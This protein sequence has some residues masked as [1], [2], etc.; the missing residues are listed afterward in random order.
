MERQTLLKTLDRLES[1]LFK[2][3][4]NKDFET[5][6]RIIKKENSLLKFKKTADALV[7][8]ISKLKLSKS[9]QEKLTR[10]GI[11]TVMDILSLEPLRVEDYSLKDP[12]SVKNGEYCAINGTVL[13]K[14]RGLRVLSIVLNAKGI[15]IRCNWF[16]LTPYIKR[17]LSSI[18]L[19]DEVVCLGKANRDGFLLQLNHPKLTKLEEFKPQ[20]KI[21][22]PSMGL[23][24]STIEKAKEKAML[25]LPKRPFDYL[26]YSVISKNSLPLLDEFFEHLKSD[27]VNEQIQKRQKYEEMFFLLLG[28]KLQEKHLAQKTAPSIETEAGFLDEVKKH[29]PFELTNGQI[30]AIDEILKDMARSRPM[31]RLLQGDVGCGKTVVALICALAALKANYQVAIMAPTQPLAVQFFLQAENLFKHFNIKTSLLISSTKQKEA[32]YKEIKDGQIDC[33]IGTHALIEEQVEFKNLGFIVIDE[34]HRFG[35]EQ[36][37]SLSSKGKF[38]HVLLMSA[39]PIPRSLSMVLYS[40][41]SLSTIKE[42]PKNRGNLKTLHFYK[43]RRDEA[44]RIALDE[45]NKKHQVYVIVPLIDESEHFEDYKAAIRLYEELRD[46]I[47]RDFRVELLHGKIKPD[48]KDAI[49]KEFRQGKIDCLVST[50]VIEVGIDSPLATVIIIEN[51]E[52]FGLAQLHQLRGRVGRSSLDA[53]AILI[54]DNNLSDTA[55]KRIEALLKTNDGF[56]LAQLDF[57]LRGSGEILGTRQHGRD[58][59]YTNI[60]TDTKLIQ[61]VKNDIEMLLE[62]HY[63]LNEGL[64]GMLRFKWKERLNYIN[65]G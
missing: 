35:V 23:K 47:F 6:K 31:L 54:T 19:G 50:T 53:Y 45:L 24:N 44:Y 29:L 52:R 59:K 55:K 40:K 48:R 43:D 18:K 38:P 57:Q 34:Q 9:A 36:R 13:S 4:F 46:G 7:N 33:I 62:K 63:P 26:P 25:M 51:A 30:Q 27:G 12:K 5:A 41:T 10:R 60:L 8:D 42:K 22:Y 28:L 39:T 3:L 17:M 37:K 65:V 16:R 15:H 49:I 20:K 11:T 1:E 61:A 21:I 58:L 64:L 2:A 56:E 32:I 14:N